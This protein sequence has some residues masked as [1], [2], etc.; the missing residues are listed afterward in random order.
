MNS[1]ETEIVVVDGADGLTPDMLRK[2]KPKL[3]PETK[4]HEH[5]RRIRKQFE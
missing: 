2:R 1:K 3:A 4:E 5:N